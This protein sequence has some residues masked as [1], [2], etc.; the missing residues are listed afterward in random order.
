MAMRLIEI[1]VP[2]QLEQSIQQTLEDH[3]VLGV[4]QAGLSK[5]QIMVRVLLPTEET[6]AVLDHLKKHYS[7][8]EGFRVILLSVEASLPRPEKEDEKDEGNCDGE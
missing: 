2:K 4:W 5:N 1:Y 7:H 8:L 3:K 6:E